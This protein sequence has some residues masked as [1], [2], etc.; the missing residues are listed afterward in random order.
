MSAAWGP[1]KTFNR[2][3]LVCN[4]L[5]YIGFQ[6]RE[7]WT[8]LLLASGFRHLAVRT[9]IQPLARASPLV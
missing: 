6:A 2:V 7:S 4:D 1:I 5:I 8:V 3:D 9:E